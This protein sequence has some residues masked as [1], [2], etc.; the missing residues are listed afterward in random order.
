MIAIAFL[1]AIAIG[2]LIAVW[3]VLAIEGTKELDE[4]ATMHLDWPRVCPPCD[5]KCR[6]GRQCP[7]RE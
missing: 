5:H 2:A 4:H 1:L 6:Q 7:A 3:I